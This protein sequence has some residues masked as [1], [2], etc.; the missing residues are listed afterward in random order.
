LQRHWNATK[1]TGELACSTRC[2]NRTV[3]V[4]RIKKVVAWNPCIKASD[5]Q[6]ITSKGR[7]QVATG[8]DSK[9]TRPH[10]WMR[11]A[12]LHTSNPVRCHPRECGSRI[13]ER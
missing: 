3:Y 12:E 13:A 4:C 8:A 10:G 2:F 5:Y 1:I 6:F 7:T 9:V 11:G